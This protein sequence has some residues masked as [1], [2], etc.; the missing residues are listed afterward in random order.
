MSKMKFLQLNVTDDYNY[1]M[2]GG[3]GVLPTRYVGPTVLTIGLVISSGGTQYF[4][5]VFRY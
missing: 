1:G 4:G 2:G 3:G 5:G